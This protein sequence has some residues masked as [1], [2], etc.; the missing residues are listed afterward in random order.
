MAE[1]FLVYFQPRIQ[2]KSTNQMNKSSLF[3]FQMYLANDQSWAND[4]FKTEFPELE[5]SAFELMTPKNKVIMISAAMAVNTNPNPF[6]KYLISPGVKPLLLCLIQFIFIRNYDCDPLIE[7]LLNTNIIGNEEI[8]TMRFIDTKI[9][10]AIVKYSKRH[11]K[12][13]TSSF[14]E[15]FYCNDTMQFIRLRLILEENRI[16]LR[17][18]IKYSLLYNIDPVQF[19][20]SLLTNSPNWLKRESKAI[21]NELIL[22]LFKMLQCSVQNSSDCADMSPYLNS[23]TIL[24]ILSGLFIL[25]EIEYSKEQI[26]SI[27]EFIGAAQSSDEVCNSTCFLLLCCSQ[28]LISSGRE[29]ILN[30]FNHLLQTENSAFT[31]TA[32]IYIFTNQ[33]KEI[34]MILQKRL[35]FPAVLSADG[36][37]ILRNIFSNR[38]FSKQKLAEAAM[39]LVES[40]SSFNEGSSDLPLVLIYRLLEAKILHETQIDLQ[41]GVTLILK[42]VTYAHSLLGPLIR[43]FNECT[44]ESKMKRIP[45]EIITNEFKKRKLD[46]GTVLMAYSALLYNDIYTSRG[47]CHS[48]AELYDEDVF[49]CMPVREI[50]EF[51]S[52]KLAVDIYPKLAALIATR[53][54]EY[55]QTDAYLIEQ[56]QN[57]SH[58]YVDSRYFQPK[59][60]ESNISIDNSVYLNAVFGDLKANSGDA[61]KILNLMLRRSNEENLMHINSLAIILKNLILGNSLYLKFDGSDQLC[62]VFKEIWFHVYAQQPRLICLT[63]LKAL[64][65]STD[66]DNN[67]AKFMRMLCS[68]DK[69][70]Y[71]CEPLQKITPLFDIFL[72]ILEFGGFLLRYQLRSFSK[73]NQEQKNTAFLAHDSLIVQ[74][75]FRMAKDSNEH[76][77]RSIC[78]FVHQIFINNVG[79]LKLVLFQGYDIEII[80][81][82]VEHIPSMRKWPN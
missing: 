33:P 54:P 16:H 44:L 78:L 56:T 37:Q 31:L 35:G 72:K 75:L 55:F 46:Y 34:Q 20:D 63:T 21:S 61:S 12:V 59:S 17:I 2:K 4:L 51:S 40:S 32:G 25:I 65:D 8:E 10:T 73:I 42:K 52:F 15:K 18:C 3:E 58:Y 71:H 53:F 50:L 70:I 80:P 6:E 23:A 38:L 7:F 14:L 79:C 68:A 45:A 82:V 22:F 77:T 48:Q 11:P 60:N 27:I 24:R 43:L 64:V 47:I 1:A 5:Q 66:S 41:M 26:S 29:C 81:I 36:F 19:L 30:L 62:S 76:I 69:L 67:E 13:G 74:K 9:I 39:E 49:S 57:F 28:I